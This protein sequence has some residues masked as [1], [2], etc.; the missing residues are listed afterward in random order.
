MFKQSLDAIGNAWTG[1]LSSLDTPGGHVFLFLGLYGAMC[2][3]HA[4]EADRQGVLN[5]LFLVLR[6]GGKQS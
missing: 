2:L 6:P 5:A 1:F 4:S 3:C